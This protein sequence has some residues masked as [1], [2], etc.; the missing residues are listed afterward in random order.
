[1]DWG[2]NVHLYG[3]FTSRKL[4]KSWSFPE[5]HQNLGM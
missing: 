4:F 1:M 2:N 5:S 3:L